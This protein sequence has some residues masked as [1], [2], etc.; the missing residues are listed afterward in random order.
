MAKIFDWD[1]R[2]GNYIDSVSRVNGM[3]TDLRFINE[4]RGLIA[5]FNGST[6]KYDFSSSL[7]GSFAI[8]FWFK[9]DGNSSSSVVIEGNNISSPS[10]EGSDGAYRFYLNTSGGYKFLGA[11][12]SVIK[13][14]WYNIVLN[15]NESATTA[16]LFVNGILVA[17]DTS[18]LW[19]ESMD[20]IYIGHRDPGTLY[21]DCKIGKVSIYDSSLIVDDINRLYKEF[22][23]SY[24]YKEV[25][26]PS[27][28]DLKPTDLSNEDGL[29]AAYNMIPENG[30]VID[31]SG[32][33]NE[34]TI[35]GC[36]TVVKGI[37]FPRIDSKIT[38]PSNNIGTVQT[39]NFRWKAQF[40]SSRAIILHDTAGHYISIYP[41]GDFRWRL[42][43]G[44]DNQIST[45]SLITGEYYSITYARSSTT[46]DLYVNG[47]YFSGTLA[48]DYDFIYSQLGGYSDSASYNP[49]G[50][51]VDL[52]VYSRV[53]T[54]QEIQAYHDQFANQV[55][56][57]DKFI[58]E[59]VD[60]DH[61][62]DWQV[63]S[64][65]F[66]AGEEVITVTEVSTALL[67]AGASG[68]TD[69]VD[70]DLDGLADNMNTTE[71]PSAVTY[72]IITGSGFTGNAQRFDIL[73]TTQVDF[74]SDA[75]SLTN[76]ESYKIRF[77][78]RTDST[79]MQVSLRNASTF[80]VK[81]GSGVL[82][83]NTG[84][85][86]EFTTPT[87]FIAGSENYV[88]QVLGTT[89]GNY[90]EI[91]E[92]EFIRE[93]YD[94]TQFPPEVDLSGFKS[95]YK[96][97][98]C[99]TAGIVSSQSKEAY[100]TWEFDVYKG[101]TNNKIDYLFILDG[102]GVSQ[103]Q[104]GYYLSLLA[105]E[106]IAL[107]RSNLGSINSL[108]STIPAYIENLTWYRIK[109]DRTV[110]GKFY[111]FIKG[112]AFG[113]VYTVIDVSGGTGTNPVTDDTYTTSEYFVSDM[114]SGDRFTGIEKKGISAFEQNNILA[115]Y[116][117][118]T[119]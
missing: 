35:T 26:R 1:V 29:L 15:Y 16:E 48:E 77:K 54:N 62:S 92:I 86:L 96:Y 51:I 3:V 63:G 78:Y 21:T 97:I 55:Y 100:G 23:N 75:F 81:F 52:Q 101:N 58:D 90:Y 99:T 116:F 19:S 27:Y 5:D 73:I 103:A 114:D 28:I 82:P 25:N 37:N 53:L 43:F 38:F 113:S 64:G 8:N 34:G 87:A 104:N 2:K 118:L 108:F 67:N 56:L 18:T 11:T 93:V 7:S 41:N 40:G 59:P 111:V 46:W 89:A 20:N 10:F 119:M 60:S 102:I 24:P 68:T 80:A 84:S 71:S 88:I 13:N 69:W 4:R 12:T 33:G 94:I 98:E 39:I 74:R 14:K 32:N 72:S 44:T 117:S 70:T 6:S 65:V 107:V 36:N 109:I 95:S 66:K 83:T 85:A 115:A 50:A 112:G 79:N 57:K 110:E 42:N 105:D 91:D 31:I 76:G 47:M 17:S 9:S 61:F 22:Q 30:Q 106:S 49:I 45:F